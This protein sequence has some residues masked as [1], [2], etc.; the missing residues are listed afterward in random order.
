MGSS[1]KPKEGCCEYLLSEMEYY[2][3]QFNNYPHNNPKLK[4]ADGETTV[5]FGSD[6][7]DVRLV[8]GACTDYF[9][10]W[11]TAQYAPL[12]D[13]CFIVSGCFKAHQNVCSLGMQDPV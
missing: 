6:M 13:T 2:P 7:S 3:K 4:S 8:S 5:V 12:L 10:P 1:F 9:V 11:C